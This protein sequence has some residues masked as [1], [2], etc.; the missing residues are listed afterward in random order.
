MF[1]RNIMVKNV[2][3]YKK[4][5]YS[6]R[7][8]T[9]GHINYNPERGS[10]KNNASCCIVELDNGISDFY[11]S[12]VNKHYGIKLIKPNWNTHITIINPEE[13]RLLQKN[14]LW[15]KYEGLEV[16]IMYYPFPRYSGDTDQKYGSQSGRFWFLTIDCKFINTLRNELNLNNIKTPHLTI[17][18]NKDL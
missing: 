6:Q 2:E 13:A 15:K 7:L 10:M 1:R 9:K 3:D 8:I 18:K 14:K 4:K 5:L 16:D 11:R 17:G 12:L